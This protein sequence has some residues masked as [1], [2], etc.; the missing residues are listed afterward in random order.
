MLE[1]WFHPWTRRTLLWVLLAFLVQM[2]LTWL[3]VWFFDTILTSIGFLYVYFWVLPEAAILYFV[4]YRLRAHWTSTL[5]LGLTGVVGAPIDY[6]FEAIL[7]PN[8]TSPLFAFLY[9]PLFII[10]GLSADVSLTMLHPERN[11]LRASVASSLLFTA[12]VLSTI[13]FATFFFYPPAP[14]NTT[15]L[16]LGGYLIPYSLATGA[17][18]GYL[19]FS[20]ARDLA[21]QT[22]LG[23]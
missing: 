22:S 5:I 23:Y 21:P 14:L 12:V 3:I 4:A 15:W 6:Y 17:L 20:I 10:M 16:G 11:P 7:A 9:I 19:G 1:A 18:G 2:V 8:L 13:A